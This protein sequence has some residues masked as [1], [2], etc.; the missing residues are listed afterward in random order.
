[1]LSATS[2][3]L[4]GCATAPKGAPLSSLCIVDVKAQTCW[5]DQAH[6][7]GFTFEEIGNQGPWF[8]INQYDLERIWSKLNQ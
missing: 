7:V 3:I 4:S 1:M 8:M 6:G 5:V 2:L